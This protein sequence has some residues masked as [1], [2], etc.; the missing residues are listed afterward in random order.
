MA[1]PQ[2][3]LAASSSL[4]IIRCEIAAARDAV[5]RA[6]GTLLF[7]FA[8]WCL[9]GLLRITATTSAGGPNKITLRIQHSTPLVRSLPTKMPETGD[10]ILVYFIPV[11][12]AAVPFGVPK[13]HKSGCTPRIP[14]MQKRNCVHFPRSPQHT[15]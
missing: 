5:R 4:F 7:A 1:F 3:P 12:Y 10:S 14:P 11:V 13:R 9:S 15:G 6:A 2:G 8:R